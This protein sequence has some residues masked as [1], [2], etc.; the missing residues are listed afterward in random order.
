MSEAAA[1]TK[2]PST[3]GFLKYM[4][5]NLYAVVDGSRVRPVVDD[6]GGFFLST[7]EAG[8]GSK[9]Q[10]STISKVCREGGGKVAGRTF[11]FATVEE[12]VK[13]GM[14][15]PVGKPG[16]KEPPHRRKAKKGKAK[17]AKAA[18]TAK[19]SSTKAKGGA[20]V[21]NLYQVPYTGDKKKPGPKPGFKKAKGDATFYAVKW[22]DGA[23][24]VRANHGST[25]T[26]TR[27]S[28]SEIPEE[29]SRE[30]VWVGPRA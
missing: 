12:C 11:R 23:V 22:P 20:Q 19:G 3:A 10:Q 21:I 27:K 30:V 18:K 8:K 7:T 4:K 29:M 6:K 1:K 9:A 2:E 28:I 13:Q 26:M 16:P 24:T 5:G 25:W 17:A 15:A 14:T